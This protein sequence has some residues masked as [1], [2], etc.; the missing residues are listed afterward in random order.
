MKIVNSSTLFFKK[1]NNFFQKSVGFVSVEALQERLWQICREFSSELFSLEE[2]NILLNRLAKSKDQ[3]QENHMRVKGYFI[4]ITRIFQ[5]NGLATSLERQDA[6]S[7]K[8]LSNRVEFV[9]QKIEEV[10]EIQKQWKEY[11]GK[12]VS[13]SFGKRRSVTTSPRPNPIIPESNVSIA[14][15]TTKSA[16]PERLPKEIVMMHPPTSAVPKRILK[17]GDIHYYQGS[18]LYEIALSQQGVSK[19][20][21]KTEF[22]LLFSH[23]PAPARLG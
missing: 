10:K 6:Q 21:I 5:L 4:D 9:K 7:L 1:K 22:Q 8:A 15:V 2:S 3:L 18:Q 16:L 17:P 20:I 14:K 12:P 11:Q 23:F 13:D 19:L